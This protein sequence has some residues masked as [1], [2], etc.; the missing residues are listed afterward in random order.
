MEKEKMSCGEM[1]VK[2]NA[3]AEEFEFVLNKLEKH[4]DR[5]I[6]KFE[7]L[8]ELTGQVKDDSH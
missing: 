8:Y 5:L 7:R 2:I 1:T 4:V 6:N 3:D